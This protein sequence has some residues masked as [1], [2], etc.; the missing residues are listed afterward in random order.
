MRIVSLVSALLFFS[1][2]VMQAADAKPPEAE[3]TPP[4]SDLLGNPPA[5]TKQ[6]ADIFIQEG[7]RAML[8]SND[9][10]RRSVDAAVSFSKAL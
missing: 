7:K 5:I 9:N 10:P 6:Q 4:Q 3:T 1:T 2:S 8:E